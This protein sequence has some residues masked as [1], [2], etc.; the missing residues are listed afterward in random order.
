ML[1]YVYSQG[2]ALVGTSRNPTS[3]VNIMRT[4]ESAKVTLQRGIL[5]GVL[6]L[7]GCA[8]FEE[9]SAGTSSR[10]VEALVGVPAQVWKDA[11][12]SEVWEYPLGPFGVETYMVSFG[13]DHA[14]R[15][16]RQVLTEETIATLRVGMSRDDVRRLLGKPREIRNIDLSDEEIW[17]WRY[18]EWR[19]RNMELHVQFDRASGTLKAYS[20]HQE[21]PSGSDK[22]S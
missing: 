11:D 21:E 7:A 16:V 15:Q 1:G 20:R 6:A 2:W 18:R 8:S 19:V 10:Q 17:S 13:P 9:I 3:G 14:V 22:R 4:S 12:G 5:L